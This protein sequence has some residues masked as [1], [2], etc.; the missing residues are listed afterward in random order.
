MA[1]L[2]KFLLQLSVAIFTKSPRFIFCEQTYSSVWP[3]DL[4]GIIQNDYV[5]KRFNLTE[6]FQKTQ[7]S[8]NKSIWE[9]QSKECER[10]WSNQSKL[11]I[12][13]L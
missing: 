4:T 5:T 9:S 1:S 10:F 12:S 3:V 7:H 8:A 11:K 13:Y 6:D 2:S